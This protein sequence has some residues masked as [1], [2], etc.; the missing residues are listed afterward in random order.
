MSLPLVDLDLLETVFARL[1]RKG[2][3]YRLGGKAPSLSCDTSE[4]DSIDCSG[5]TRY[6]L[7][8]ATNGALVIPDG[9]QNQREWFENSGLHQVG[10]YDDVGRYATPKRLFVCFIKPGENSA[11]SIGHTWFVSKLD[12][13]STADTMESH[14]GTGIDT[15]PWNT[16]VLKRE[17]FSGFEIPVK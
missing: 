4:I 2:V 6:A 13:D 7:A 9:S 5:F 17:F 3:S 8:K 11:G 14:G 12:D 1:E 15:R 10:S 16:R